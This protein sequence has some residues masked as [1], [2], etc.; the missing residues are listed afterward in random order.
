MS[1]ASLHDLLASRVERPQM[2]LLTSASADLG[3][4]SREQPAPSD[5]R[6]FRL[7]AEFRIRRNLVGRRAI[8][9]KRP[10]SASSR[11]DRTRSSTSTCSSSTWRCR[12]I[13]TSSARS[14]F[15]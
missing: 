2:L 8:G 13:E 11:W 3:R 6:I 12:A 4:A 1:D 15:A 5:V 14:T 7:D 10:I 9:G